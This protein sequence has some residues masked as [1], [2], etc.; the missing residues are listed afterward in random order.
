MRVLQAWAAI[1]D[2]LARIKAS[3]SP[4]PANSTALSTELSGQQ[5][6]V[7]VRALFLAHRESIHEK[8][9]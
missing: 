1:D 8:H 6:G 4:L 2:I 9:A 5:E 7:F 3:T